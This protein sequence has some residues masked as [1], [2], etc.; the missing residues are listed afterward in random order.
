MRL[1]PWTCTCPIPKKLMRALWDSQNVAVLTLNLKNLGVVNV[2]VNDSPP[3]HFFCLH[4]CLSLHWIAV[5]WT[6]PSTLLLTHNLGFIILIQ[7][8]EAKLRV[9]DSSRQ[10]LFILQSRSKPFGS[11]CQKWVDHVAEVDDLLGVQVLEYKY[12]GSIVPKQALFSA[13]KQL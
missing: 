9:K 3:L 13:L 10:L 4:C 2:F 1:T 8:N 11:S 12:R 6:L 5:A 7:P